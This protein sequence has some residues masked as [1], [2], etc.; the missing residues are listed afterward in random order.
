[1]LGRRRWR[2][3]TGRAPTGNAV[4]PRFPANGTR[5]PAS[6]G[7]SRRIIR[8]ADIQDRV[9]ARAVQQ[10]LA[11]WLENASDI[12]ACSQAGRGQFYAL[13]LAEL[14]TRR[15]GRFTWG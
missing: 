4:R 7:R 6:S 10:L 8:L 15:L 14:L 13:A 11:P 9:I 5:R 3:A 2:A 1:M 12:F